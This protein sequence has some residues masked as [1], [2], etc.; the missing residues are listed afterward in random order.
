[1]IAGAVGRTAQ[2]VEEARTARAMGYH[3]VLLSLAALKGASEDE[4]IEHCTA[5]A[6]EMPLVGF[7]LQT[8]VGGIR[9]SRGFW[10]RFAASSVDSSVIPVTLPPG[11]ARLVTKPLPIGSAALCMTMGIVLVAPMA[12]LI[13]GVADVTITSTSA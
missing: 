11:R 10:S 8:A 3:A 7:Y 13:A 4:L 1:M 9:L 5:V 2:A 6:K 12:A